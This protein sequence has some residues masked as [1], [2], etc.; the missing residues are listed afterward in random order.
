MPY[1]EI[2]QICRGQAGDASRLEE[3]Q[4]GLAGARAAFRGAC[5]SATGSCQLADAEAA[6]SSA[7]QRR[8]RVPPHQPGS[9][10][11]TLCATPRRFLT[12][13]LDHPTPVRSC[14][15]IRVPATAKF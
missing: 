3:L 2:V 8:E 11:V 6:L 10:P 7:L 4:G 14:E 15:R 1:P 13:A 12:A 5:I 9:L